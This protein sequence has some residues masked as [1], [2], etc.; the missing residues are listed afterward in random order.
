MGLAAEYASK[1]TNPLSVVVDS[2]SGGPVSDRNHHPF[3]SDPDAYCQLNH[4]LRPLSLDLRPAW[5]H[6][7]VF[8]AFGRSRWERVPKINSRRIFISDDMVLRIRLHTLH[9][10]NILVVSRCRYRNFPPLT[11]VSVNQ[12]NTV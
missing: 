11:P 8:S 3:P 6:K 4:T 5:L 9:Y 2:E 7:R 12:G 10:H 1:A